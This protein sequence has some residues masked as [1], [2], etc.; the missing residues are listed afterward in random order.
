MPSD[1]SIFWRVCVQKMEL[2]QTTE[3]LHIP[4]H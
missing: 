3:E 4:L 2:G 1:K